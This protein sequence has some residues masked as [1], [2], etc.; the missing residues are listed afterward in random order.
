MCLAEQETELIRSDYQVGNNIYPAI[1]ELRSVLYSRTVKGA[2]TS[3]LG[4][5]YCMHAHRV[6]YARLPYT[7]MHTHGALPAHAS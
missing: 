3:I 7:R 6:L 5:N 4:E 1:P 2:V